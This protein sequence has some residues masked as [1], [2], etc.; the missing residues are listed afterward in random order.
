MT[1][2]AA[3]VAG[4][5]STRFGD[6]DKAVADLAGVPMIRR[7]A[8]RLAAV[9]DRLVVNCRPDQ[10]DAVERAL[11]GYENPVRYAEDP[12]PDQGPM[13]GIRTALRGVEGWGDGDDPAFVVACDMPFVD[14]GFVAALFDRLDG[15][16]AV[17]PRVDD[18]WYQTT[19]AV[20]RAGPMAAACEAALE[21][22]DRKIIAPL[23]ELDYA[24]VGA[25]D[26]AALGVADRTF[27]NLNTR[28]EFREAAES[29][30]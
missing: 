2:Y 1:R 22:G 20:Y 5:R 8:D 28:D 12:A 14:P 4:G 19:H 15:H 7:V 26:L 9:T 25:D 27:E 13:A 6:R 11:E 18:E 3:V 21:R 10:R 16:D 23:F 17:V 30:A 29:F 24:V